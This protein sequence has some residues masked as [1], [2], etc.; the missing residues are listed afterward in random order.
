MIRW[1]KSNNEV[2]HLISRNGGSHNLFMDPTGSSETLRQDTFIH[3]ASR[4]IGKHS[5]TFFEEQ[6]EVRS[7]IH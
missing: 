4:G 1:L 5:S 7:G 2:L 3:L 6:V